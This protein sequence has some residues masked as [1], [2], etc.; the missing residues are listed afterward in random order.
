MSQQFCCEASCPLGLV[1]SDALYLEVVLGPTSGGLCC[2]TASCFKQ[3]PKD[4]RPG[5]PHRPRSRTRFPRSILTPPSGILYM[6]T[7]WKPSQASICGVGFVEIQL[8]GHE[9]HWSAHPSA[10]SPG[11]S[12]GGAERWSQLAMLGLSS[13]QF[14]SLSYLRTQPSATHCHTKN[15]T[16]EVLRVLELPRQEAGR[17]P[18]HKTPPAIFADDCFPTF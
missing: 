17:M 9:H 6:F 3:Q 8:C 11:D 15:I 12:P 2:R 16:W 5:T 18:I 10:S 14:S 1:K 13:D 4:L 7:S